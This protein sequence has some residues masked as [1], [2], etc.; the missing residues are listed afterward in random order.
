MDLQLKLQQDELET[1]NQANKAANSA[2]IVKENR[3]DK[4]TPAEENPFN[5]KFTPLENELEF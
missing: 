1:K 5:R 2:R 4:V 3:L